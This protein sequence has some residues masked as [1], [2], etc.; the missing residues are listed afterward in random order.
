MGR[1]GG[2]GTARSTPT[3]FWKRGFRP[4][5]VLVYRQGAEPPKMLGADTLPAEFEK[6]EAS[7]LNEFILV[8]GVSEI[9]STSLNRTNVTSATGL[10]L[11][12]DQDDTP[13]RGDDGKHTPRGQGDRQTYPAPDAAVC[14]ERA[15]PAHDGRGETGGTLLFQRQRYFLGRRNIRGGKRIGGITRTA[16][17]AHLRIVQHGAFSGRKRKSF[18]RDAPEDPGRSGVRRAGKRARTHLAAYE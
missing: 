13:P 5:K 6:E 8:S 9:S 14:D 10:Q 3:N 15:R 2:G 1:S 7:L 4:G 16:A 17:L 18:R 11:L 12:I